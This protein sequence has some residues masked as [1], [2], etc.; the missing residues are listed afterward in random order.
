MRLN[1]GE[2]KL[3][4]FCDKSSAHADEQLTY[5][6]SLQ[7][8]KPCESEEHQAQNDDGNAEKKCELW[9]FWQ[10]DFSCWEGRSF[11]RTPSPMNK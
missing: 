9:K 7:L 8:L 11:V 3:C 5:I 4:D 1:F 2:L 10:V 6:I